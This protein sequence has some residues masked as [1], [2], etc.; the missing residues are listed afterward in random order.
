MVNK[1]IEIKDLTLVFGKNKKLGLELLNAGKSIQ[2][3]RKETGI[4]IG[5]N[6]ISFDIEEGEMFVIVGL[7]GSGKSSLIRCMNM[8]NTP[9]S[10]QLLID[11]ENICDY[12][13]DQLREFRRNRILNLPL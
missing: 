5:V 13:K 6:N 2:E 3:I 11:G 8:L 12:S 10:G 9:T 1:K 7:S 4:A